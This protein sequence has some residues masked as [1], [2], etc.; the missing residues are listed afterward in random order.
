MVVDGAYPTHETIEA[1]ADTGIDLIGPLPERKK[2]GW[3]VLKRNGVSPRFY[4]EAFSYDPVTDTYRCPAGKLLSFETEERPA[5]WIKRRYR[6][7]PTNCRSCPFQ[8]QCCPGTKKGRSVL[9]M[10]KTAPVVAFE[11]KM[12]T[13]QAQAIYKERAG[14]PSFPT[15]GSKRKWGFGSF[16]CGVGSRWEWKSCGRASPMTSVSGFVCVGD[17]NG[18]LRPS[19]TTTK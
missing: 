5:G 14:W 11:A 1:M 3:D 8:S 19:R 6:A 9:R 15:P 16:D 12:Q 17:R 18:W 13:E 7:R 10:E 2:P 4:P